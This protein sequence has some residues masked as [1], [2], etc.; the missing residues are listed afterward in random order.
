MWGHISKTDR[1]TYKWL[2]KVDVNFWEGSLAVPM[3][4]Q[5]FHLLL[6]NNYNSKNLSHGK[7]CGHVKT[8]M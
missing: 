2:V 8:C 1:N 4:I 7:T 3:K 5:I 6:T